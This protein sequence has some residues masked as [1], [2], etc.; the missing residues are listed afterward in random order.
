VE[1]RGAGG[2][3]APPPADGHPD[4]REKAR[5]N[6]GPAGRSAPAAAAAAAGVVRAEGVQPA[7]PSRPA[8]PPISR[9]GGSAVGRPVG[10]SAGLSVTAS[11]PASPHHEAA[12]RSRGAVRPAVQPGR[13]PAS[14]PA[15]RG[16]WFG[17]GR[18]LP[19]S[20][21]RPPAH[22]T[23]RRAPWADRLPARNGRTES[24]G[25]A[26]RPPHEAAGEGFPR[27]AAC[28]RSRRN[29]TGMPVPEPGS[30][31]AKR[32]LAHL[33]RRRSARARPDCDP[34]EASRPRDGPESPHRVTLS[35]EGIRGRGASCG[36]TARVLSLPDDGAA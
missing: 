34:L 18:R 16:G 20:P 11:R 28:G 33:T 12:G 35:N 26:T 6:G 36:K 29:S 15:S 23:R 19:G 5:R 2:R 7:K 13:E 3:I 10:L 24:K 14:P 31:L 25:P 27:Q 32:E 22:L 1:R 8:G 21:A 4:D 17:G 9:G 30:S